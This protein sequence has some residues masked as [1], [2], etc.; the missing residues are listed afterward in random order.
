MLYIA[1]P[2]DFCAHGSLNQVK[3]HKNLI[4]ALFLVDI[5]LC[6]NF[7]D[8]DNEALLKSAQQLLP[9]LS[10]LLKQYDSYLCIDKSL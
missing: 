3:M 2:Y 4:I 8:T 7:I 10:H 6:Y 5:L 1:F 9:L